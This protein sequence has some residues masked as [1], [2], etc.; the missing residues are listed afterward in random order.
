MKFE[1]LLDDDLASWIEHGIPIPVTSQPKPVH[2]D[3]TKTVSQHSD[4]VRKRLSEYALFGAISDEVEED[5]PFCQPLHVIVKPNAKPRVCI[6]LSRNL[7]D[8]V[9]HI[10]NGRISSSIILSWVLLR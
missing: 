6:D 1:D 8:H 10:R 4:L 9:Q 5:P 7:N 3:N 2:F